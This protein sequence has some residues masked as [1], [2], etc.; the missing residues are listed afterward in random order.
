MTVNRTATRAGKRYESQLL[1]FF[2]EQGFTADRLHLAGNLDEGDLQ[3]RHPNGRLLVVEA[4]REKGFRP[5]DWRRQAALE[6]DNYAKARGLDP[7]DVDY[8]VSAACRNHGV[9]D[10]YVIGPPLEEWLRRWR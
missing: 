7:A 9:G 4:K 8:I 3:V 2:R 5:A 1:S 6:R 10:S